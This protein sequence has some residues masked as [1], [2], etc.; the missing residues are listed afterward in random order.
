MSLGPTARGLRAGLAGRALLPGALL[1]L[2]LLRLGGGEALAGH[3]G[4]LGWWSAW[5]GGAVLLAGAAAGQEGAGLLSAAGSL[6]AAGLVV[7][8]A[9]TPEDWLIQGLLWVAASG[10]A[11]AVSLLPWERLVRDPRIPTCVTLVA[12]ILPLVVGSAAGGARAWLRAGPLQLQPVELAKVG[13]I[14]LLAGRLGLAPP[15]SASHGISEPSG[16]LPARELVWL[17]L[18]WS[19]FAGA[20]VAQRDLGG[21]ALV[22][23]LLPAG[24]LLAGY[25]ARVPLGALLLAGGA[26]LLLLGL[27]PHAL[28]R[29]EGMRALW[30]LET[31]GAYQLWQGLASLALGGLWGRPGGFGDGLAVPAGA[32]DLPLAAVAPGAGLVAVWGILYLQWSIVARGLGMAETAEGAARLLTGLVAVLWGLETLLPT[33]GWLGLAPLTGLPLPLVS[34]GGSALV[35]HGILLGWLL[36]GARQRLGG[37][38]ARAG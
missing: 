6:A 2:G 31:A 13:A 14:L 30:R 3:A 29:V 1:G 24:L 33:A 28:A 4:L 15:G 37:A 36:W 18:L 16:P 38:G 20:L 34:R 17:A 23:L 32:T 26:G 5:S 22:A 8:L 21:A 7:R 27:Y 25:P 19:G 10:L 35:A 12:L 9:T 11:L